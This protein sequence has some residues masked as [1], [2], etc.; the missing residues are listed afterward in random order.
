MLLN[1]KCQPLYKVLL[2]TF[3]EFVRH[4][5]IASISSSDP[6]VQGRPSLLN[7][8]VFD[9]ASFFKFVNNIRNQFWWYVFSWCFLCNICTVYIDLPSKTIWQ[10]QYS[11]SHENKILTL[12]KSC[13]CAVSFD[14]TQVLNHLCYTLLYSF[15]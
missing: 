14:H 11:S 4:M 12:I 2:S 9:T 3:R 10:C 7:T 6:L 15:C 1:R 13:D 5:L 8:E